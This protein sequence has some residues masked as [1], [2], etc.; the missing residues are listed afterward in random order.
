MP[1]PVYNIAQLEQLLEYCTTDRQKEIIN[2]VISTGNNKVKAAEAL[3]IH[4][5]TIQNTIRNVIRKA[6]KRGWRQVINVDDAAP[7]GFSASTSTLR[8][9][10]PNNPDGEIVLQWTK[11]KEDRERQQQIFNEMVA[12]MADTIPRAKPVLKMPKG[13]N[14]DL[15]TLYP[16]GDH[17]FGMR[18]WSEETGGSDYDLKIAERLLNGST[19][20]LAENGPGCEEALLLLTGDFFHY[21]GIKPVT[22]QHGHIL[23]ADDRFGR[24]IRVGTRSV[25]YSIKH[26][27]SRHNKVHVIVEQGNHDPASSIWLANFLDMH[28]EHED[29]VTVDN[30]P[31][32]F[33]VHQFGKVM[34]CSNHGDKVKG[35][36]L[37]LLFADK[38]NDV[39]GDT[40]YRYVHTCHIHHFSTKEYNG[41]QFISHSNLA[42][43]DSH[44]SSLGYRN[45]PAMEA[46]FYHRNYGKCGSIRVVPQ[47]VEELI[48]GGNLRLAS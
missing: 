7:D 41:A 6:E 36:K 42:P 22:P 34:H 46:F 9:F 35:E 40:E 10:S 2:A 29:R 26:L 13:V 17:H 30:S 43:A 44:S 24:M 5:V 20:Y 27:L 4:R 38:W 39:W 48:D 33:H 32:P 31:M 16:V 19:V 37:I 45:I 11:T 47:L 8:K 23:D 14:E 18:A 1:D 15:M 21:D 25:R 12:A 3:G 28:Y